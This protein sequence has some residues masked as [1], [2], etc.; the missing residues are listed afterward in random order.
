MSLSSK[1]KTIHLASDHA[2]FEY[3]EAIRKWLE[4][5]GHE[6]VDHGAKIFDSLD[7]FP[8]F[9]KLAAQAVSSSPEDSY[10]IIFGGSGQGEAMLAN[11]FPNV[12]A[13]AY[14]GGDKKI[15]SL[16][17]AHNDANILSI[18]ARFV[19]LEEARDSIESWL[20]SEVVV[21]DKYRRRNQKIEAITRNI[22]II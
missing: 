5:A 18:G 3:K 16:S 12:R 19:S 7:D 17:R 2:G 13:V 4:E 11:R 21:D 10:G 22:R 14:Y 9:I 20:S 8:D 1:I 15:I 6:V